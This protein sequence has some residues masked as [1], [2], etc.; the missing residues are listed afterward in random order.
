MLMDWNYLARQTAALLVFALLC[1]VM[2][3]FFYVVM[4]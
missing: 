2:V 4:R 3:A 1:G